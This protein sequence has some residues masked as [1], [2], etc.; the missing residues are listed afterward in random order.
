VGNV[1]SVP[2]LPVP[3]LP[4]HPDWLGNT[5]LS[6]N[7]GTNVYAADQ[8]HAPYGDVFNQYG[9]TSSQGDQFAGTTSD[10]WNTVL[11]DTPNR[12]LSIAG[13]WLSPDPANSGWNQ[14][15]Y[16]TNPN[17]LS[18]PSGLS[19]QLPSATSSWLSNPYTGGGEGIG[20]A[21]TGCTVDGLDTS[22]AAAST[23]LQDGAISGGTMCSLFGCTTTAMLDGVLQ[24]VVGWQWKEVYEGRDKDGDAIFSPG[25]APIWDPYDPTLLAQG[26]ANNGNPNC[27]SPGVCE[28]PIDKLNLMEIGKTNY[29]DPF[30]FCSTHT[31][32]DN[33]TGATSSHVDLFNPG[34]SIPTGPMTGNVPALPFHLLFDALPDAIYRVTGQYLLPAGRGWCQ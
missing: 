28:S 10:F 15:A 16:P 1:P 12:E 19:A 8:A 30:S 33:S 24:R 9:S 17:S 11:Y 20:L 34:T 14:Y 31:T 26:A 22:C 5:R 2:A 4:D 6:S 23:L 13:R 25:L 7:L 27:I 32:V 3:A 29:R 18:D 21:G